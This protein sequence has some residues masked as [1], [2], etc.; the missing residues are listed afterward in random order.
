MRALRFLLTLGG[1]AMVGLLATPGTGL[2][3]WRGHGHWRPHHH[4]HYYR[5]PPPYYYRPPPPPVYYVPPPRYYYPPPPPPPVYYYPPR[6]GF[7]I[8][9]R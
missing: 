3:D 2:A 9:I 8:Y 7:G 4:R 6:P 1:L 5:P